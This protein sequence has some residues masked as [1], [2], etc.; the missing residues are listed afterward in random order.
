[1][2]LCL[3]RQDICT[4]TQS[5]IEVVLSGYDWNLWDPCFPD[6]LAVLARQKDDGFCS[7]CG[8]PNVQLVAAI[9]VS[10][11]MR[12]NMMIVNITSIKLAWQLKIKI[13][14][15]NYIHLQY[16]IGMLVFRGVESRMVCSSCTSRKR[17]EP[18]NSLSNHMGLVSKIHEFIPSSKHI[19]VIFYSES[20]PIRMASCT[21]ANCVWM[22]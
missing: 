1:M 6:I 20:P 16:S 22:S 19:Y 11:L 17:K 4:C 15:R 9:A 13:L 12:R 3:T 2:Y 14:N 7:G 10:M 5:N 8:S 18:Q 21:S